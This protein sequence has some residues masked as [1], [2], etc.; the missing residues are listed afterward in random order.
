V[1]LSTLITLLLAAVLGYGFIV[2]A[3]YVLQPRLLF[4]PDMP[5]RVVERDPSA[6]GLAYEPVTI[7]TADGV[8]LSG[9]YVPADA[10]R[11]VVVFFH[12]NAGNISH[13]LESLQIFNALGLDTLI[14]DYR[15]YGGSE[16]APSEAGLKRDAVAAWRY[17]TNERG[18]APDRI[19]LFGRSLGAAVAA[20][21]AADI[22]RDGRAAGLIVE[23]GFVSVPDLGARLYPWLPVR[24]LSRFRFPTAEYLGTVSMPVLVIHSR[25]DEIIPFAQGEAL[26]QAAGGPKRFLEIRG[27]HN[28]G[29]WVS[30]E[31]YRQGLDGFFGSVLQY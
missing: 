17:L 26:F 11:G 27:G 29:F 16:G 12:G 5:S 9:W 24:Q 8:S 20:G 2:A 23:S 13:R 4:L 19:V 30:G 25:D 18:I 31:A 3:M 14:F 28:D 15:G 6:I 22:E 21:L 10:G 7:E 1:S